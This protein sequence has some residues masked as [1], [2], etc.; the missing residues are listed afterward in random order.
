MKAQVSVLFVVV[1]A[2]VFAESASSGWASVLRP[3]DPGLHL[4]CRGA[5]WLE[6]EGGRD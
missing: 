1:A 6:R 3:S 5:N 4:Q 2:V